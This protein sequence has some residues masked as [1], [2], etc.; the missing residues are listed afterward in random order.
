MICGNGKKWG[1][2]IHFMHFEVRRGMNKGKFHEAD[3][4]AGDV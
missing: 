3:H 1:H 4:L 2:R